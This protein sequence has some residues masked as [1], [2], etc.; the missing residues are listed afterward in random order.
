MRTFR[1]GIVCQIKLNIAEV[2]YRKDAF[3]LHC[4]DAKLA[5]ALYFYNQFNT[6]YAITLGCSLTSVYSTLRSSLAVSAAA[7]L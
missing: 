2:Y 4:K 1:Y 3:N 5:A 7:D 6:G